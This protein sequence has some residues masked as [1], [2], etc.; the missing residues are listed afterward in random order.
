MTDRDYERMERRKKLHEKSMITSIIA[1]V[2]IVAALIAI[3]IVVVALVNKNKP[4]EQPEATVAVTEQPTL[5]RPEEHT[6]AAKSPTESTQPALSQQA[7]QAPDPYTAQTQ[8]WENPQPTEAPAQFDGITSSYEGVLHYYASGQTSYGYNWT[9]SGGGG[10][11]DITCGYDFSIHQYDFIITGVSPG[12]TSFYLIYYTAD[13]QEV[14]VPM[15]VTVDEN[16]KV[17]QL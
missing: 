10:I 16:L 7:T 13:D 3:V 17:T 12:T 15:T 14:S 6:E 11:V 4:E 1:G 9:Y 2:V 8:S 5:Y